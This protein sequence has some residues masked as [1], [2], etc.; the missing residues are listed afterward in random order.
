MKTMLLH[1]RCWSSLYR[2]PHHRSQR[3][4]RPLTAVLGIALE[5]TACVT[6]TSAIAWTASP[7]PIARSVC[8][9]FVVAQHS[10]VL[11]LMLDGR[12]VSH[13]ACARAIAPTLPCGN[14]VTAKTVFAAVWQ[15]GSVTTAPLVR[16]C[17]RLHCAPAGSVLHHD[18][19][20]LRDHADRSCTVI[21]HLSRLREPMP[22]PRC[23]PR[24]NLHVLRRL[25]RPELRDTCG[26]SFRLQPAPWCVSGGHCHGQRLVRL[27]RALRRSG[28]PR[29][30]VDLA[31]VR[32]SC[33]CCRG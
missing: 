19:L 20:R 28:M 2:P 32:L 25:R 23:M 22:W 5:A 4:T 21:S 33:H 29:L 30:Y 17:A 8:F 1:L 14:R 15:A 3:R 27:L 9:T 10:L 16:I 18:T 26:L 13:Q 6:L 7:A 24:S 12:Y 31:F 11:L